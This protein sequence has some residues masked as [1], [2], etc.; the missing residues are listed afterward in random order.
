MKCFKCFDFLIVWTVLSILSVLSV[1]TVLTVL[2]VQPQLL[3]YQNSYIWLV[4]QQ[5]SSRCKTTSPHNQSV[6]QDKHTKHC[7]QGLSENTVQGFA[8]LLSD[9]P[10]VCP[11]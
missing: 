8:I 1:L 6:A 2:T 3:D 7:E 4:S 10:R 9:H 5:V 11:E